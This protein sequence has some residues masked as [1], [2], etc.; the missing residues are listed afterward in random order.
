M[1]AEVISQREIWNGG[2]LSVSDDTFELDSGSKV[3]RLVVH[4]PG[5]VVVVP[6]TSEGLVVAI[7]Q[8]RAAAQGELV[9]LCAGKRDILGE[10]PIETARR[11]LKEELGLEAEEFV[12]LA[13]FMNSPG[14]CDEFT[15]LFMARG[16][17]HVGRVPQSVE[18][19]E[20]KVVVLRLEML[21]SYLADGTVK[22]A[23][24]IIGLFQARDFIASE[25]TPSDYLHDQQDLI[26]RIC[27]D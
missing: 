8:F 1:T 22:D 16:L 3:S 12:E 7:R 6:V 9:E 27:S 5:A 17:S 10:L 18:E 4:H 19:A 2:F 24:T 23:K 25:P 20:S 26:E 13:G 21:A 14:F 11:E 15:H